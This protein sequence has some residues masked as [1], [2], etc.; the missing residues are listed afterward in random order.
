MAYIVKGARMVM[1]T[2]VTI[3]MVH[4]NQDESHRALLAAFDEIHRINDLMSV[5]KENSEV[6]LLNKKGFYENIS[7]DTK[8]VIQRSKYFSELSDGAFDITILPILKLWEYSTHQGKIPTDT[9]ITGQAKLVNYKDIVVKDGS[10]AFRKAGMGITTAGVGKGYAVD[11]AIE[12]L[13]QYGI[14]HALVNAGGD[15]RVIGGKT[16]TI[17]WKIA[18]RDPRN[19]SRIVTTFE[20]FDQAIATSGAYQRG[21]NDIINPR[22]GRPA[23]GILSSTVIAETAIDADILAT[24]ICILGSTTGLELIR[25][26]ENAKAFIITSDGVTLN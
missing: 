5:H 7:S 3:T 2:F 23:Q 14:E 25:K 6:S 10:I 20:F 9:E 22:A 12:A 13:Q 4:T 15:I 19:K 1:G 8:Y 24:C 26:L 18:V 21:F 16:E 17:P 11:K